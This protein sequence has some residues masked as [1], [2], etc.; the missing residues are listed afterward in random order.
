MTKGPRTGIRQA[1]GS[2][3]TGRFDPA[4]ETRLAAID[5]DATQHV[6]GNQRVQSRLG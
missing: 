3:V 4:T 6:E 1:D 5:R 2:V